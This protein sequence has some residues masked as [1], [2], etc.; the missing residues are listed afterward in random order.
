LRFGEQRIETSHW[1]AFL[2]TNNAGHT[3]G[4][5]CG[6]VETGP[7]SASPKFFRHQLGQQLARPT[8]AQDLLLACPPFPVIGW[9][10]RQPPLAISNLSNSLGRLRSRANERGHLTPRAPEP[11]EV[12]HLRRVEPMQVVLNVTGE[13]GLKRAD[14]P[15]FVGVTSLQF[16]QTARPISVGDTDL[17]EAE[18][19][20]WPGGIVHDEEVDDR[21]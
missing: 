2:N 15:K 19:E 3:E 12:L 5:A 18:I 21:H 9:T 11:F 14:A 4:T 16:R 20:V 6:R 1:L 8:V 13:R 7:G 17:N 10:L